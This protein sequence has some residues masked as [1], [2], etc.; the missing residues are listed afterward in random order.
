ML[1]K[2]RVLVEVYWAERSG[3]DEIILR[4]LCKRLYGRDPDNSA[5][6]KVYLHLRS[7]EEQGLVK[8]ERDGNE[9]SYRNK[10]SLTDLGYKW[11]EY[12]SSRKEYCG[13]CGE[14][15]EE[16][17]IARYP[18]CKECGGEIEMVKERNAR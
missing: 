11:A 6:N 14:L 5:G 3:S 13:N 1:K 10:Y 7:L 17:E 15:K 2:H 8:V 4:E 9:K 18:T 12:Y 16:D